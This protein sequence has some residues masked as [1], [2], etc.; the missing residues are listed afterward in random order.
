MLVCFSSRSL[1]PLS[2]V[3][4]VLLTLA[5]LL[6]FQ[7]P[8]L[9]LVFQILLLEVGDVAHLLFVSVDQLLPL[10]LGVFNDLLI[11]SEI[12]GRVF[13]HQMVKDLCLL[14]S[15]K[16]VKDL[17]HD[18]D[19]RLICRKLG[20]GFSQDLLW[21]SVLKLTRVSLLW[22]EWRSRDSESVFQIC[23]SLER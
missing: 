22:L 13:L 4:L 8:H 15:I 3:E 12:L 16:L 11:L 1:V 9:M 7:H 19:G 6:S 20:D 14:G 18:L 17:L 2:L 5:L 21:L 23:W 10:G